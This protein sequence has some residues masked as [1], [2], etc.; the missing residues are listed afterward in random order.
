NWLTLAGLFWLKDGVN[1]FGSATTNSVVFPKGATQAGEFILDGNEVMVN[2]TT[3]ARATISGKA[4]G[5]AKL[6]PDTTGHPTVVDMERLRFYTIVRGEGVGIRLKDMNAQAVH[7]FKGMVFFPLDLNY[8]V[9]AK[10]IPGNGKQTIAVPNVLGDVTQTPIP[11]VVVF[12]I[13]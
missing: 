4:I 2:F 7:D 12:T 6:E 8:R 10:F 3:V 11:G 9:T 5:S 1:T 13:N